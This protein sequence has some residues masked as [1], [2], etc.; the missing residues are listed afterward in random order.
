MYRPTHDAETISR[1][2]TER[3]TAADADRL[4]ALAR[5]RRTR[6]PSLAARI[7]G[8]FAQMTASVR[9]PAITRDVAPATRS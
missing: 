2:I 3:Y 1:I 6:R 9:H 4:A 7:G 5:A 8:R